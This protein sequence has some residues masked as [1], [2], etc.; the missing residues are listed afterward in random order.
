V[1]EEWSHESIGNVEVAPPLPSRY[2]TNKAFEKARKLLN[3][4][5]RVALQEL[6]DLYRRRADEKP[7]AITIRQLADACQMTRMAACR[8][9]AALVEKG[10]IVVVDVGTYD[11]KRKPSRYRL[12]FFPCN[13]ND[14]TH[15]YIEDVGEWRRQ[16]GRKQP[17]KTLP[18][19]TKMI[20]EVPTSRI[21]EV[22]DAVDEAMNR[23]AA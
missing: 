13:G 20:V 22:A 4:N 9:I 1:T 23:L 19:T 11:A 15:D 14:A 6:I 18:L 5:M 12:T 10:F 8:A 17:P 3:P 7:V 21:T 16:R 2:A